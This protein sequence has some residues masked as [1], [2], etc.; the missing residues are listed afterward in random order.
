MTYLGPQAWFI[1]DTVGNKPM[2]ASPSILRDN[3]LVL[4]TSSTTGAPCVLDLASPSTLPGSGSWPTARFSSSTPCAR[5]T[6]PGNSTLA[7]IAAGFSSSGR[8]WL[9]LLLLLFSVV[10]PPPGPASIRRDPADLAG[11]AKANSSSLCTLATA[12]GV[13]TMLKPLPCWKAALVK[14]QYVVLAS[15]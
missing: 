3:V 2:Y 8:W 9:V 4:M 5:F 13:A 1:L 12:S 15:Q 14:T 10:V 11:A 7:T 6:L